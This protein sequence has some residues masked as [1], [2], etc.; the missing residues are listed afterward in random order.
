[1]SRHLLRAAPAAHAQGLIGPS[2]SVSKSIGLHLSRPASFFLLAIVLPC[3]L[4][5]CGVQGEPLPPRIERPVQ[6]DDLAV[7][8]KGQV[9]LLSFTPPELA[10]DGERLTK[11]LEIQIFRTITPQD[12]SAPEVPAGGA[13]WTTLSADDLRHFTTGKKVIY[14]VKLS[15]P[16][17]GSAQGKTFTFAVRGVTRGFRNRPLEGEISSSASVALL[18]VSE[19]VTNLRA[20][21]T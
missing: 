16:E 18:E 10:T 7:V 6:V 2:R 8:Q 12:T 13:P 1:M 11:Q 21:A 19:P 4:P 17:Y 3:F 5:G 9:L 15:D 14:L 20:R